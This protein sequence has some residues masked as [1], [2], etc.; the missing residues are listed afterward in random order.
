ME[1]VY[2]FFLKLLTP[3]ARISIKLN[4][5]VNTIKMHKPKVLIT[6]SNVSQIA[7]D[8]LSVQ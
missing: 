7:V 4:Y 1:I 6:N 2:M 5:I 3:G 8:L